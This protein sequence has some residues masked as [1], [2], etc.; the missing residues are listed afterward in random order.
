MCSTTKIWFRPINKNDLP[1]I[2]EWRMSHEIDYYMKTSPRLTSDIQLLWFDRE[3]ES[4]NEIRFMIMHNDN[5]IG[6]VYFNSI[7]YVKSELYGP[8]WFIAD[9]SNLSFRDIINIK[10]NSNKYAFQ[11]LKINK[12]YG[13]VMRDNIGVRK[14]NEICGSKLVQNESSTIMKNSELKVFDLFS[15]NKDEF[16]NS[17]MIYDELDFLVSAK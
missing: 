6:N 8:G 3:I 9:K 11:H 10:M 12:I 4:G 14:I 1:L 15:L 17:S 13:E 5:P 16:E 2:M 7:D